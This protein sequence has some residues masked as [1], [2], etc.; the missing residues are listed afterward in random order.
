MRRIVRPR[1]LRTKFTTHLDFDYIS[2]THSLLDALEIDFDL[3]NP[4]NRPSAVFEA[5]KK[6]NIFN[7]PVTPLSAIQQCKLV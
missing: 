1:R 5:C 4:W 6:Q 3:L 7:T 2:F